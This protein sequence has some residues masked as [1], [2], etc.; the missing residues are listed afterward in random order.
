MSNAGDFWNVQKSLSTDSGFIEFI[1]MFCNSTQ[2]AATTFL[3]EWGCHTTLEYLDT[4]QNIEFC[5]RLSQS[6]GTLGRYPTDWTVE[7]WNPEMLEVLPEHRFNNVQRHV[8]NN[9][10]CS[11]AVLHVWTFNRSLSVKLWT[12]CYE[13]SRTMWAG[14]EHILMGGSR[15]AEGNLK[16]G[17][18]GAGVR[19]DDVLAEVVRV[20]GTV[21]FHLVNHLADRKDGGRGGRGVGLHFWGGTGWGDALWIGLFGVAFSYRDQKHRGKAGVMT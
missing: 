14:L 13:V 17:A 16:P 3:L 7:G 4:F 10:S 20:C 21:T 9:D 12:G 19:H 15:S 18:V 5:K 1:I 11:S 8:Q 6:S 2:S